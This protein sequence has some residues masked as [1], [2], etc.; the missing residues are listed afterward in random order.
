LLLLLL[1]LAV[2]CLCAGCVAFDD[3][4]VR[5]CFSGLVGGARTAARKTLTDLGA[6]YAASW[7]DACTHLVATALVASDKQTGALAKRVPIVSPKWLEA[8][9]AAGARVDEAPFLL[10]ATVARAAACAATGRCS[11]GGGHRVDHHRRKA[12]RRRVRQVRRRL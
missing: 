12:R 3:A 5:A 11:H 4:T 8:C 10:T 1:A 2:F 9:K 6:D 7:D